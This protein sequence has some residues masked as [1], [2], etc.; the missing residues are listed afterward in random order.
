MD[1]IEILK[2]GGVPEPALQQLEAQGWRLQSL[3]YLE[4]GAES[5]MDTT[6]AVC[7]IRRA[8]ERLQELEEKQ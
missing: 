2:R 4:K 8:L 5:Q 6:E 7:N 3:V 1:W